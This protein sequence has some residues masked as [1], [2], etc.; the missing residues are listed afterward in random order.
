VTDDEGIHL[1]GLRALA[2]L[3]TVWRIVRQNR[4]SMVPKWLTPP[5]DA[6]VLRA[7]SDQRFR[8]ATVELDPSAHELVE[9]IQATLDSDEPGRHHFFVW[10]ENDDTSGPLAVRVAK[11]TIGHLNE[12]DSA[13]A[14][15]EL[16]RAKARLW[17]QGR[18]V[19]S[20]DDA[21]V[22]SVVIGL[23]ATPG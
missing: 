11:R 15:A 13:V 9:Q 16:T 19:T 2:V 5:P 4:D 3:P 12:A 6:P 17:S 18:I 22:R 20:D 14:R 8:P 23:P 7:N 21:P 1:G 10:F